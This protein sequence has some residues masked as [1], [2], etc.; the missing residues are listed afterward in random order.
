M[1]VYVYEDC[2][3]KWNYWVKGNEEFLDFFYIKLNLF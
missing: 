3:L 2:F 1:L